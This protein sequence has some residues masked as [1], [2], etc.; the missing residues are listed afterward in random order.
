M[1]ASIAVSHGDNYGMAMAIVG[2]IVAVV[3]AALILFSRERR[4][5]DMT[6]S[7]R[8][9]GLEAQASGAS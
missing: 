3:I 5:I 2:G 7:A 6:K 1:Q 8:Q 9:V 4:G